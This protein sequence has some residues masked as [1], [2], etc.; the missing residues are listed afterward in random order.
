MLNLSKQYSTMLIHVITSLPVDSYN[1]ISISYNF[2]SLT[3]FGV[4]H[5]AVSRL[6]K[7]IVFGHQLYLLEMLKILPFDT[8]N[9]SKSWSR[10]GT[11]SWEQKSFFITKL[12]LN[13]KYKS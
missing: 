11:G 7:T 13:I 6:F 10:L 4:L 5:F 1:F 8:S 12:M 2:V 3:L 9:V